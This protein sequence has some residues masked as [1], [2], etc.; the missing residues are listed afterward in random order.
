M[1]DRRLLLAPALACAATAAAPALAS[2]ATLVP[3]ARCA[4]S[5]N[6]VAVTGS[7]FSPNSVVEV[8][9]NT[10]SGSF[11]TDAVGAFQAQIPAP[12]VSDFATHTLTLTAVDSVNPAGPAAASFGVG[13]DFFATNFP[14][15]G[16]PQSTTRW[17]F[18]GFI[19][20][21]PIYGHFRYRGKTVRNYR[22]GLASGPCGTLS[23]MARRLPA[24]SHPGNW[25]VQ[26][27]Q[28]KSYNRFTKPRRTASFTI[29]RTYS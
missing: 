9:G 6:T 27:D 10:G 2:A 17:Q 11:E 26:F 8:S 5:G 12:S 15:D 25:T 14:I 19:T 3:A 7:G 4:A 21:K 18:A 1:L 13:R 16:R 28:V 20:G 29:V 22:Y 24:K 23:V